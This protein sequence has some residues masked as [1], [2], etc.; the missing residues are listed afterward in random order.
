MSFLAAG[1]IIDCWCHFRQSSRFLNMF[2]INRTYFFNNNKVS[3]ANNNK[4]YSLS[5]HFGQSRNLGEVSNLGFVEYQLLWAKWTFWAKCP[6][7]SFGR[8][9]HFERSVH[10][11]LCWPSITLGAVVL[12]TI[13]S[14]KLLG[15][16]VDLV[17]WEMCPLGEVS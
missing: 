15:K 8:S 16:A 10:V 2:D 11:R 5:Q 17:F 6:P 4:W 3:N 14:M 9:V 1:M 13:F 7:T 12:E